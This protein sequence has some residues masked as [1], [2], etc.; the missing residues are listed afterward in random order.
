MEKAELCSTTLS[1]KCD[2]LKH[3]PPANCSL[4]TPIFKNS[5]SLPVWL[6]VCPSGGPKE[7]VL[8]CLSHSECPC[9]YFEMK[10]LNDRLGSVPSERLIPHLWINLKSEGV[11]LCLAQDGCCRRQIKNDTRRFIAITQHDLQTRSCWS[12]L[13]QGV[14]Q[15][16]V[17]WWKWKAPICLLIIKIYGDTA[18]QAFRGRH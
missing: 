11:Q 4:N 16:G 5:H 6:L 13:G 7:G 17:S 3:F 1:S 8:E 10:H 15:G 12:I 14:S 18:S 9:N 2:F